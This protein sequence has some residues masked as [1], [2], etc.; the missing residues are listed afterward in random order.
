[1]SDELKEARQKAAAGQAEVARLEEQ[2]RTRFMAELEL[3]LRARRGKSNSTDNLIKRIEAEVAVG[4]YRGSPPT[5]F[6]RR[7]GN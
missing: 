3:W 7:F 5:S 1:M 6:Y 2:E 4:I